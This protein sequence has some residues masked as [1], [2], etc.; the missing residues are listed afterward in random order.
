MVFETLHQ[1]KK[2][3]SGLVG[4]CCQ[5]QYAGGSANGVR[6]RACS[7]GNWNTRMRLGGRMQ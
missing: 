4:E 7:I 2:C 6:H 5:S 1:L 3:D